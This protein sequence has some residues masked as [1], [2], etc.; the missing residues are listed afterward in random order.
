MKSKWLVIL[1]VLLNSVTINADTTVYY[2]TP[3]PGDETSV[4][5][6][7]VTSYVTSN[8]TEQVT[9]SHTT[10]NLVTQDFTD[11]TWDG[12]NISS[13]HGN[14]TIAGIGGRYV[15]T[16]VNQTDLGLTDAQVQRGFSSNFGADIWFWHNQQNQSVDITQTYNDQLGN[17]TTLTKNILWQNYSGSSNFYTYSDTIVVGENNSTEGIFTGRFTFNHSDTGIHRAADLKLPTLTIDYTNI[18]DVVTQVTTPVYTQVSTTTVKYCYDF[19][20][21]QCPAQ[22]EIEAVD[23]TIDI[24]KEDIKEIFK[25]VNFEYTPEVYVPEVYIPEKKI[26]IEELKVKVELFS[27]DTVDFIPNFDKPAIEILDIPIA[28]EIPMDLLPPIKLGMPE[29]EMP[30]EMFTMAEVDTN[31]LI[32]MFSTEEPIKIKPSMEIE[33]PVEIP[34]E[35]PLEIKGGPQSRMTEEPVEEIKETVM[36]AATEPEPMP[37]PEPKFISEEKPMQETA[38]EEEPV[39]EPEPEAEIEEQP[40]SE[41]SIANETKPEPDNPQQ[42]ETIEEP[43]EAEVNSEPDPVV[44][45]DIETEIVEEKP[46]IK[47]DLAK[48]EKS[49]KEQVTNKLQQITATLDVVDAILSKEMKAQ[50]PDM[51][52]YIA[53]NAVMI[54]NRQLSDGNLNFFDQINLESYHKTIYT[55]PTKLIAMVGVDPVIIHNQKMNEARN[56]TNEAYYKLKAL[57]EAKQ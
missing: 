28:L 13:R 34:E 51:S 18:T 35:A 47:I 3:N 53:R 9:T 5:V 19:N 25:E 45:E 20:P 2:N 49:I 42:E 32:A 37:E 56:N 48:I 41:E 17:V 36:M 14:G 38:M 27:M 16:T 10:E 30:E 52:S 33:E 22:E 4:T 26:E 55:D 11:G 39:N 31:E 6:S 50:E 46:K 54:D 21:P 8:V 15:E 40:S 44:E 23:T 7:T 12:T 1:L 24:F 43:A 57:L 29:M